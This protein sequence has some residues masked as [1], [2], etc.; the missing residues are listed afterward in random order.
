MRLHIDKIDGVI[1]Q[2][3]DSTVITKASGWQIALTTFVILTFLPRVKS[4]IWYIADKDGYV[5]LEAAYENAQTAL[6]KS[7]GQ[8][9]IPI[10]NYVFDRDDLEALFKIAEGE[11]EK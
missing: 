1:S 2:W 10:I 3:A 6:Q 8:L 4:W 7:G 11:Q 5:D 9:T